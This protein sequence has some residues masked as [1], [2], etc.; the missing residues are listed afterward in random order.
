M[1]T[2]YPEAPRG[3]VGWSTQKGDTSGAETPLPKSRARTTTKKRHSRENLLG[4]SFMFFTT[5]T[6][7]MACV[8]SHKYLCVKPGEYKRGT[9]T[10]THTHT[11]EPQDGVRLMLLTGRF[12]TLGGSTAASRVVILCCST[13][14]LRLSGQVKYCS[15]YAQN[16]ISHDYYAMSLQVPGSRYR[17]FGCSSRREN[18]A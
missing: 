14:E 3:N 12:V 7:M 6:M 4:W 2:A 9:H 18:G 15:S 16:A 5:T 13:V 17:R 8:Q 11:W 10:D 1:F